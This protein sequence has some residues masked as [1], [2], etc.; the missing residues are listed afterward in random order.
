MGS[1]DQVRKR[2]GVRRIQE[3][4]YRIRGKDA[5]VIRIAPFEDGGRRLSGHDAEI[6]LYEVVQDFHLDRC[7]ILRGWWWSLPILFA[8][9]IIPITTIG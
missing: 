1:I 8:S 9:S 3:V 5:N 4:I 7:A 6:S 2:L